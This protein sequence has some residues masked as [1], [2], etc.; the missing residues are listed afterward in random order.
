MKTLTI[1]S[2]I[3]LASTPAFARNPD[4]AYAYSGT[5]AGGPANLLISS[6]GGPVARMARSYRNPAY[7]YSGTHAGGPADLLISATGGPVARVMR[8]YRDPAYAY[9]GTHAGGPANLLHR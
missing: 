8:P 2:L 9:S 4:P 6:T 7:A 3:A 1:V 5:H